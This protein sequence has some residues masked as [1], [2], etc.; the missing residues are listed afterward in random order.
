ML[1]L[2]RSLIPLLLLAALPAI[3][4]E[5]LP[6][7]PGARKNDAFG[8][9]TTLAP[10]KNYSRTVYET[11]QE[12]ARVADFYQRRLTG[13]S[14]VREGRT[15]TFSTRQGV[16]KLVPLAQGTRITLIVGPR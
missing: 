4:A 10:G 6:I 5:D 14:P 11:Q 3:S 12:I 15:I 9:A 7:P 1:G 8:G 2:S 16:V 13:V